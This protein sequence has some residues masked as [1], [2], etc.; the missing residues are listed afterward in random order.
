[1]VLAV[2][3]C[4]DGFEQLNARLRWSLARDG[5][6]ERNL[7]FHFL[8]EMKMQT[9]PS[10]LFPHSKAALSECPVDCLP[11][12]GFSAE[13][14]IHHTL[15]IRSIFWGDGRIDS[16]IR[17]HL[18][19]T[20]RWTVASTSANTSRYN[21][22]L[23]LYKRKCKSNPPSPVPLF[24]NLSPKKLDRIYIYNKMVYILKK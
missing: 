23:L 18:N 15:V 7:Y 22:S 20:A 6:T 9:N 11:G 13:K 8:L 2:L 4:V 12:R 1:M 10:P 5:S 17:T 3:L 24:V 16:E 14:R 19:A 21:N